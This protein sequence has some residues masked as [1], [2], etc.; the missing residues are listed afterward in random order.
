[1]WKRK[2]FRA[3]A[4]KE[5]GLLPHPWFKHHRQFSHIQYILTRRFFKE[6]VSVATSPLALI[7]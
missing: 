5:K 2:D 7:V 3:S 4:S 6:N 1:M